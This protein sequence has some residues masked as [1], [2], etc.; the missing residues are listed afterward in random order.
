MRPEK[1]SIVADIVTKLESSPYLLVVDYAGLNVG[2]FSE[3]RS[4]LRAVGAEC[5][6]TKN[7]FLKRAAKEGGLPDFSA[8]LTGQTAM[9][10]GESDVCAAAKVLKVFASEFEKPTVKVGV[11]DGAPLTAEEVGKLADLPP[12]E[13]LLGKLLGVLQAPASQLVRLLNE[14]AASLARVLQAKADQG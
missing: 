11:L 6:V 8:E 2:Q 9:V 1:A 12:R 10:V 13:V 14:P 4:R 5:R 7:T 3:L